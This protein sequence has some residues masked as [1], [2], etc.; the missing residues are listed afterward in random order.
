MHARSL[1]SLFLS[2][3]PQNSVCL[4][5]V[6][7]FTFLCDFSCDKMFYNNSDNNYALKIQTL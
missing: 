4:I 3:M 1:N 7:L 5:W 2:E 6:L